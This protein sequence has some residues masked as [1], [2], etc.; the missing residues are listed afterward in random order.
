MKPCV[1]TRIAALAFCATVSGRLAEGGENKVNLDKGDNAPT[2][3]AMDQT[4]RLWKSADHV[5]K[6]VVVA[7]FFPAA[8]T[9]G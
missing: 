6:K 5:G 4:G 1:I 7:F 2:F 9:G 3:Q 8:L